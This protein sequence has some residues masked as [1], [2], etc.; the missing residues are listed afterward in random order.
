[1]D[2]PVVENYQEEWIRDYPDRENNASYFVRL[3]ASAMIL[4]KELFVSLDGG[5]AFVPSPRR[6]LKNN[7]FI[8]WYDTIQIQL[9][10]II[11]SI[12]WKK[13]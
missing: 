7:E 12:L 1:M 13:I 2:R 10:N 4:E 5:R 9:A 3:E 8:Y 11:A 6:I